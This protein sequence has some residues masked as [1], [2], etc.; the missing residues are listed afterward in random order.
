MVED[1][2]SIRITEMGKN[3]Q[4]YVYNVYEQVVQQRH[5]G[6][7]ETFGQRVH[8]F[9]AHFVQERLATPGVWECYQD[10]ALQDDWKGA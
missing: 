2:K 10:Y 4:H 8:H 3:I 5:V 9:S 7:N 1:L 6:R